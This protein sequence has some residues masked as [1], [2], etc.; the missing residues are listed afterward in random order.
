MHHKWEIGAFKQEFKKFNAYY[1]Y[2]L[3][4]D[5]FRKFPIYL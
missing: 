5:L 1:V 2:K 4:R 3:V